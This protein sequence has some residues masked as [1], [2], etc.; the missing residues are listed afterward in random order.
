MVSWMWDHC[1]ITKYALCNILKSFHWISVKLTESCIHTIIIIGY[2]QT[3]GW[4]IYTLWLEFYNTYEMVGNWKYR[5]T[6]KIIHW[7]SAF[8][9][10]KTMG[11]IGTLTAPSKNDGRSNLVIVVSM[12][13][14]QTSFLILNQRWISTFVHFWKCMY[15]C[16]HVCMYACMHVCIHV[17]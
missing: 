8:M 16:M 12:N 14:N 9:W 2:Y 13:S 7:I 4:K 15:A 6:L 5:K 11:P 17:F 3:V 10:S 1:T